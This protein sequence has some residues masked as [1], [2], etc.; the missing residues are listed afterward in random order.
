MARI[1]SIKPEFPQSESMGRISRDARLTFILLWTLA[2]DSGRL[3]GN[4]RMLAS[5]LFPYD[6]DAPKKISAWLDELT[7]EGVILPYVIDSDNYIE[8]PNFNKHQKIDHPS[9]SKFPP[10]REDSR[11]F[12]KPSEKFPLDQGS[13]IKDQGEEGIRESSRA[14]IKPSIEEIKTYCLERNNRVN[15]EKW[16]AHYESNG[17]KVGRSAMK[18]WRAAVRTWETNGFE[19][20]APIKLRKVERVIPAYQPLPSEP[21]ADPEAVAAIVR[22]TQV[23]LLRKSKA[24]EIA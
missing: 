22:Q 7:K 2:D 6:L 23:N 14:F 17:W 21:L 18:D 1:R 5:L 4:S 20:I 24:M 15:P 16:L 9:P 3:R 12:A 8:I 19:T 11:V 13:R 10:F